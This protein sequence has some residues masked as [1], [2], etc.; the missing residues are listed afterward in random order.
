MMGVC[1]VWGEPCAHQ[2]RLE[3]VHGVAGCRGCVGSRGWSVH[4]SDVRCG[5]LVW[6]RACRRKGLSSCRARRGASVAVAVER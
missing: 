3:W 6:C 4:V 5:V 2:S 1:L